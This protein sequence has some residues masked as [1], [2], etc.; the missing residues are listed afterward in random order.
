MSAARYTSTVGRPDHARVHRHRRRSRPVAVGPATA[1]CDPTGHRAW[2]GRDWCRR[3]KII[4]GRN[5]PPVPLHL[6]AESD[7]SFPSGHATEATAV[8]HSR[9]SSPCCAARTDRTI[10][11]G[12]RPRS[13][14]VRGRSES[15]RAGRALAQRRDRGLGARPRDGAR[16][17][18]RRR[19][20]DPHR[21]QPSGFE[22]STRKDHP[23]GDQSTTGNNAPSRLRPTTTAYP[24]S[25]RGREIGHSVLVTYEQTCPRCGR[26]FVGDDK[27]AVADSV[28]EHVRTEHGHALDRDVVL[29]HLERVHPHEREPD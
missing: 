5:R 2:L 1:G 26:E 4:V 6:V 14:V 7:P 25:P 21:A 28:L 17:H 27:G 9:S 16:G 29:A 13:S 19:S 22:P 3:G 23:R 12:H 8:G 24:C 18:H 20:H 10:P 15:P 11:D